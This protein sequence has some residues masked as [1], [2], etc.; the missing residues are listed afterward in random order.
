MFG[1]FFRRTRSARHL[2]AALAV[3]LTALFAESAPAPAQDQAQVAPPATQSGFTGRVTAGDTGLP[4]GYANL[5]YYRMEGSVAGTAQGTISDANG[6]FDV[7]VS[8]G[9]YRVRIQFIGYTA[10]QKDAVLVRA[11]GK[12][13]LDVTLQAD[14]FKVDT[15]KIKADAIR[16]TESSLLVR[17]QLAG[18]VQDG[19]SAEQIRTSTDSNAA[20]VVTRVTGV[21][22]VDGKYVYVRGLGERYSSAQVNGS[23]VASPEANRRVLPFDI[24]PAGFLEN[25]VIQ[26]TYTPDQPGD[27]GG[28]AV[29]V[30]TL[31]FPSKRSWV[32]SVGSGAHNSTTGKEFATYA[33]GA[34]DRFGFDD[35]TREIPD[36]VQQLAG[37]Q[38]IKLRGIASPNGF[39]PAQVESLGEAFSH[40]WSPG[41]KDA[42][43]AMN[44]AASY[45]D[46]VSILGMPLGVVAAGTMNSSFKSYDYHSTDYQSLAADGTL[47][48]LNDF[49][50]ARSSAETLVGG[51]VNAGWKVL[52][53]QTLNLR[54]MYNHSS[55]DQVKVSEGPTDDLPTRRTRL[56]FVE[57]GLFSA[58]A[59]MN[60]KFPFLN[61]ARLEWRAEIS[62]ATQDEPDRRQYDYELRQRVVDS[63]TL[64]VWE[65]SRRSPSSGFTRAYSALDDTDRNYM[66]NAVV[67]F[68]QWSG[69]ESQLK[70][71]WAA[72]NKDRDSSIRR[73]A[74]RY[75]TRTPPDFSETP[76]ELLT[77]EN[78]GGSTSTFR[79][80]EL[81]RSS[82]AYTASHDITA[83]YGMVELPLS[84][85]LRFIG[86]V[87]V[88]DSDLKVVTKSPLVNGDPEVGRIERKDTLPA[89]NLRLALSSRINLRG[90]YSRTLNR[91]D[92]RE[93]TSQ[94]YTDYDRDRTFIGN[95]DLEQ[96]ELHSWDLRLEAFPSP[97]ETIAVSAFTKRIDHPIEYQVY[98]GTGS[99]E[100]VRQP[101]N[102][103]KGTIRGLEFETRVGL[104]RAWSGLDRFGFSGNLSRIDSEVE[105]ALVSGREGRV[106]RPLTGQSPYVA[107]MALHFQ[108]PEG[109]VSG[110]AQYN[111]F[112]KRLDASGPVDEVGEP[113]VPDIY[114]QPRH[115]LDLT[116]SC[117]WGPARLKLSVE[118]ILGEEYR[119]RQ[120]SQDAEVRELGRTVSLTLG[121]GSR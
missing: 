87:R 98:Q 111:V 99:G 95:P 50:V 105:L 48:I 18:A 10:F 42:R 51:L 54:A 100:L 86:G 41:S 72:K 66:A 4:L 107:N 31:D 14:A 34:N 103:E 92:L 63:D 38:P 22:L 35:G 67:P 2:G 30:S 83:R 121:Y 112:G 110:S 109:T 7:A 64:D 101:F 49:D 90:A 25:V 55:E 45:G 26:K 65:L 80:E 84:S 104:G 20:E 94:E 56:R 78:I 79:V 85:R 43:P 62:Q 15:I 11:G 27:F 74:F 91:P 5:V 53:S 16:N 24:F 97:E 29:N 68:P 1:R 32:V 6:E 115:S 73:F 75:P 119:T 120:G 13:R 44:F 93:L 71:G 58:S 19:I 40:V 118:N 61:N 52:P 88:E 76:E 106:R 81:T 59:G 39:T 69:R 12:T 46:E 28:G 77:D 36:L 70:L 96:A 37:S 8:P 47:E 21:S 60:H 113:I 102:G 3:V 33:G 82:D 23:T 116:G 9:I 108:S 89:A 117:R 57:R 17:R 114:E